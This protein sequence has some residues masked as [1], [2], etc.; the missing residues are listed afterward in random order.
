MRN[1]INFIS[2]DVK[3]SEGLRIN[4]NNRSNIVN[5]IYNIEDICNHV[6]E[7]YYWYYKGNKNNVISKIYNSIDDKFENTCVFELVDE[8]DD[9]Y[10]EIR[11]R[12]YN[13]EPEKNRWTTIYDMKDL[14]DSEKVSLYNT[15]IWRSDDDIDDMLLVLDLYN[16][17]FELFK[18]VKKQLK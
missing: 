2:E 3:V 12:L 11:E 5:N 14:I 1:I 18:L 6:C 17:K 16:E 7:K 8:K 13:Y 4:K 15:Q 9:D 10:K